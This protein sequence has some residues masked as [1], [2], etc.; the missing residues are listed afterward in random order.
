MRL[1]DPTFDVSAQGFVLSY[2]DKINHLLEIL[3]NYAWQYPGP[4]DIVDKLKALVE[5]CD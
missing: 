3:E 1:D 4:G 2:R 5:K